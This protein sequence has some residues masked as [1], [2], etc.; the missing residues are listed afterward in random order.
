MRVALVHSAYSSAVPSGENRVVTDQADFLASRGIDVTVFQ[1]STDDEQRG[2]LYGPLTA[3]RVLLRVGRS[4]L[5]A[6]RSFAPDVVHVHNTFPNVGS[7]WLRN[8][9]GPVAVSIH[10]YRAGCSNGLLMRDGRICHDCVEPALRVWPAIRHACYRDSRMATVPVAVSRAGFRHDLVRAGVT[11][12]TTSE[13]SDRLFR[14]VTRDRIPSVVIP[15][16]VVDH[17]GPDAPG[18]AERRGW[19][20]VSRLSPE[21]GVLKLARDWPRDQELTIIGDGP[22][23]AQIEKLAEARPW[24]TLLASVPR[25]KLRG[26][27]ARHVGLVFPSRWHEVAPQVVVEAMC[28]GLPVV[29]FDGNDVAPLVVPSGSGLSYHDADSLAKAVMEVDERWDSFHTGARGTYEAAWTPDAWFSRMMA[30]YSS[31]LEDH[32]RP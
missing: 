14:L 25:D 6:L 9:N 13:S 20:V 29:A 11:A 27:L 8:W 5:P 22:Q 17:S 31:L 28:A 32:R 21:K 30:L 24:V 19:I 15:N 3:A 26:M 4:P 2:R 16:F 18:R 23:W 12:V 10:N 1:V 7:R